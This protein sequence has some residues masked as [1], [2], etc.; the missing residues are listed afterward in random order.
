M[1]AAR[2]VGRVPDGVEY[3]GLGPLLSAR[4]VDLDRLWTRAEQIGDACMG[5]D[6]E[7]SAG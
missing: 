3:E 1:R 4:W 7:V 2:Q 5:E 6:L